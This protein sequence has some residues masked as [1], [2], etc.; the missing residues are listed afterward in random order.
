MWSSL[1]DFSIL[2]GYDW[3]TKFAWVL[4]FKQ[5]DA[6]TL[7]DF[8]EV[9]THIPSIDQGILSLRLEKVPFWAHVSTRSPPTISTCHLCDDVEGIRRDLAPKPLFFCNKWLDFVHLWRPLWMKMELLL[10]FCW[11]HQPRHVIQ[12]WSG[13]DIRCTVCVSLCE[14]GPSQ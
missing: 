8:C 12:I 14:I 11:S 9:Y 7:C 3:L 10:A 5:N 6:N 4:R 1:S 2:I 13:L